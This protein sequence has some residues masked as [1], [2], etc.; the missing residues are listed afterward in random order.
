MPNSPKNEHAERAHLARRVELMEAEIHL[1]KSKLKDNSQ[2][3]A[4]MQRVSNCEV[5]A[6]I[7]SSNPPSLRNEE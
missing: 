7:A 4:L 2:L 6:G 5:L 1:L 3:D